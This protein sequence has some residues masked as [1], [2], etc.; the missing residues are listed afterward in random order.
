MLET[1]V[2]GKIRVIFPDSYDFVTNN[3]TFE[4]IVG[5]TDED[6]DGTP[7]K[8]LAWTYNTPNAYTVEVTN[9]AKISPA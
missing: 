1:D 6:K 3:P 4:N 9:F 5:L 2:G 8:V 7:S